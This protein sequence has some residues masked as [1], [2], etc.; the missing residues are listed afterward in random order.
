MSCKKHLRQWKEK[1][2]DKKYRK[3]RRGKYRCLICGIS[4]LW[5]RYDSHSFSSA[6]LMDIQELMNKFK[7][8]SE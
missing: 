7:E 1:N 8:P 2:L 5:L 6:S 3:Y 4:F